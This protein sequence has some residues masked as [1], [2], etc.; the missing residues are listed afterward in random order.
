MYTTSHGTHSYRALFLI[1]QRSPVRRPSRATFTCVQKHEYTKGIAFVVAV[2]Y[3]SRERPGA[4]SGC[5]GTP[6]TQESAVA[7]GCAVAE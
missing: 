5:V 2:L 3:S 4:Y 6:T 7:Q 1:Q